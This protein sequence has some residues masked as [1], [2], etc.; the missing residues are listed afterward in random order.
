MKVSGFTFIRNAIKYD[1]PVLES[2]KS[3]LPLVN[4]MVIA[5]G[6]SDDGTRQLIESIN[7]DKIKI[8]DTIWD[9]SLREGATVLAVETNKAFHA[10][11]PDSDWAFYL[12][13]DECLHENDYDAIKEALIKHKDNKKVNG[14]LFKYNHFFG[15]YSYLGAGKQWYRNEI[16]IIKNDK[17]IKSWKDAQG[18]RFSNNKKLNVKKINAHIYHYGW[19]KHPA[20]TQQK[21]LNFISMHDPNFVVNEDML[22]AQF[23][24]H[25]IDR[26][27]PFVGTHPEII[28]NKIE[29]VNWEF[30]YDDTKSKYHNM[31]L[32]HKI[33]FFIEGLTG[34]RI[35]EYKNYKVV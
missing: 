21:S 10:I 11:S 18:F 34:Y 24:Y 6:N 3:L 27:E 1:Y 20:V 14:L 26:L 15:N 2:I 33:S 23:D 19:V 8:I 5:V 7:D 13:A 29:A 25:S 30:K 16:R 17:T 35:G 12:Q 9:D 31:K 4:E 22:K 28:K 32:K